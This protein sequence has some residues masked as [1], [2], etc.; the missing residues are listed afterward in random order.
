MSV[1]VETLVDQVKSV[2]FAI[3]TQN[4]LLSISIS[5]LHHLAAN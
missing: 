3:I 5:Q 4:V 1:D 2:L